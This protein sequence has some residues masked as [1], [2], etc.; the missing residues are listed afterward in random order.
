MRTPRH[1]RAD[2]VAAG[3]SALKGG[4]PLIYSDKAE[5]LTVA[6]VAKPEGKPEFVQAEAS[7]ARFGQVLKFAVAGVVVVFALLALLLL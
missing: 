3:T 1:R 4:A 2:L 7:F 5:E 6:D